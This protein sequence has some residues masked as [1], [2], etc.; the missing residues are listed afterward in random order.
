MATAQDE[1]SLLDEIA[2][3]LAS[4][5]TPDQLLSYH[6]SER[7]QERAR[8]LLAK[9]KEG[10]LSDVEQRELDQF[11]HAEILIRLVKARVRDKKASQ[12]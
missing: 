8:K 10:R 2:D 4:S 7:I 5:P 9:F 1:P 11:Q 6:P 12:P 3:F